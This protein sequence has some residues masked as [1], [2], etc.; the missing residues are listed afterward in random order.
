MRIAFVHHPTATPD[1]P[2]S[3]LDL[4]MTRA[5]RTGAYGEAEAR[6]E[7]SARTTDR[8]QVADPAVSRRPTRSGMVAQRKRLALRGPALPPSGVDGIPAGGHGAPAVDFLSHAAI[9][10]SHADAVAQDQHAR[11][12]RTREGSARDATSS[13]KRTLDGRHSGYFRVRDVPCMFG[14]IHDH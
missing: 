8:P 4:R 2:D 14:T 1:K 10:Q 7:D 6:D 9:W 13:C 12:D 3:P 5:R 11:M